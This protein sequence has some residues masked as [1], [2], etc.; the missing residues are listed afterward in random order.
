MK[1][2]RI[3]SLASN[4]IVN[5]GSVKM[6]DLNDNSTCAVGGQYSPPN[7]LSRLYNYITIRRITMKALLFTL[8]GGCLMLPVFAADF[9]SALVAYEQRNY[10]QAW[11][12]F[13]ELAEAGDA[14]A[15]YMLG[16]MY[17]QGQGTLQDF[18]QAY[19]WY[20]L[21]AA[22]G[23]RFASA[24]R[25][26][27]AE[28]MT[29]EQVASAQELARAWQQA[30]VPPARTDS[31]AATTNIPNNATLSS[32]LSATVI[33]QIQLSLQR[34]GYDVGPISGRADERLQNAILAYQND[35][36]LAADGKPSQ[37]LL[38]HLRGADPNDQPGIRPGV[39]SPADNTDDA[40]GQTGNW[41]RLL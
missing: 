21:A 5:Q 22:Q 34:L 27:L 12:G 13:D 28:R 6:A 24:A 15:Q 38:Y 30:A 18:V 7:Y 31:S 35:Q 37:Q 16:R 8:I 29:A 19:Q 9:N 1:I 14:D 41:R 26:V 32:D 39:Q 11:Q 23:Q 10:E 3:K 25:D 20:N 36:R 40:T 17:A 2:N 4:L 33:A